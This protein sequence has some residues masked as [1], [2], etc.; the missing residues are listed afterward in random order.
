MARDQN[1]RA[2]LTMIA[3]AEGTDRLH[4]YA[5][6]F[7]GGRFDNFSDHPAELGWPGLRLPD[8]QCRAAGYSPGCVSTAA[9]RYQITR[10]TWRRLGGAAKY[11]DFSP[12]AQ[13]AAAIDLLR[14][15]GA[16]SLIEQG[17]FTDAV[18]KVKRVWASLPGAG[19]AQ[20]ERDLATLMQVYADAGG[21]FA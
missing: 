7:G 21:N 6:L 13:D 1:L 14:E 18:Q 16:L 17:K 8:Y 15:N 19:Y 10:T 9:G 5:T 11:G 3:Y 12:Q 20:P 2:F 4:G